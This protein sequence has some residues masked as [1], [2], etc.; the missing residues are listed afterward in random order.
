M[1][2]YQAAI[3]HGC[4][5]I[6]K[7]DGDGQMNPHLL[8]QFIAPILRGDADY[9][10]GNRFFNLEEIHQMPWGRIFG[11]SCLSFVTKISSGYWNLFDPTNGFT[12]IHAKVASHLPF[13][14][15]SKGY[16]FETD[17]LFRLNTLRAMVV[18]IPMD[19]K[20][21]NEISN[22]KI[23]NVLP[24]FILKHLRNTVK[25]IFYNY[26]LRDM[27]L[28]SIEL[29]IGVVLSTFGVLF[30]AFHWMESLRNG[31][32]STAGTVMIAALP[33]IIGIQLILSFIG[34]DI[35]STPNQAI[36]KNLRQGIWK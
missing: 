26:Y 15:I 20:Y 4:D 2:G 31:V 19:A 1:A 29:P 9:T 34:Y 18:D 6:V 21:G 24:E 35:A 22:L 16:F 25:R 17:M 30:G 3:S 8:S 14:K 32:P 28:A 33:L 11:N 27:S 7:I 10:K 23:R 13:H 5:V 12:A 36:H